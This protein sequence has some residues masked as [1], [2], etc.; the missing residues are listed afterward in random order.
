MRAKQLQIIKLAKNGGIGRGADTIIYNLAFSPKI[1]HIDFT[2]DSL[3][4]PDTA[5]A[6]YKLVKISGSLETLIL[7]NTDINNQLKEEFFI[8]LGENKTLHYLNL[9]SNTYTNQNV[10][11][12]LAKACAMNK[13]KNGNLRY[14]SLKTAFNAYTAFKQFLDSFKVSDHSQELWY[15]DKKIARDMTKE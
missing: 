14:L 13:K 12:L 9:D 1:S 4:H 3:N 10:L 11:N 8:A 2:N 7:K 5:E 15:G 6:I